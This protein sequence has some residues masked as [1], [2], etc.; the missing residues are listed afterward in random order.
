MRKTTVE[1]DDALVGRVRVLLG[2]SSMKETIDQALREVERQEARRQEIKALIRMD[3]LDLT[4]E[5]LMATTW[6][7]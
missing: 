6:R 1:V 7:Y 4:D 2:T 3:G 5:K